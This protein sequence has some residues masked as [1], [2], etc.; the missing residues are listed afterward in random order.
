M[1]KLIWFILGSF[2][3][4]FVIGCSIYQFS[5]QFG[6][7]FYTK[8][9]L[10]QYRKSEQFNQD[11]FENQI[12]TTL[13]ADWSKTW[14]ILQKFMQ[15]NPNQAPSKN[16]EV[17]K[18]T[19]VMY[20]NTSVD[21]KLIWFGHS[22][23]L[24]QVAGKNLFFDP[25]LSDVAAPYPWLGSKRYNQENP[26]EIAELPV[27]DAVFISHDH[28]DHLDYDS[29]IELNSK[30]KHFFV[31]LAVG[32][33]L[34]EWGVS[35]DKITEMDWWESDTLGEIELTFTPSR[36]FSGR[37]LDRNNTLWGGWHLKTNDFS[38]YFSGDTGYGPHFKEIKQRLGQIDF[39]LLE[40]GQYNEDWAD[41]HMMPEQ[42]VQAASDLGAKLMMPV[43]WGAFTLSLHAWTDPIERVSLAAKMVNQALIAPQ[44]GEVVQ[45]ALEPQV[46]I[47]W[48]QNY[49]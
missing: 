28:Y 27:I 30:V 13:D 33:H 22:S 8:E 40:S 16:I 44:I 32:K 4:L 45:L 24:L 34:L 39:A 31:P 26:I 48:W 12:E 2:V 17:L 9:D 35:K 38:I 43:H 14:E 10:A 25:M 1:K 47:P 15:N 46:R 19:P 18:P 23:F 5:P 7:D 41:I 20:I 29:I 21:P 37:R 49:N 6:A 3:V 36:H 11:H 42:T